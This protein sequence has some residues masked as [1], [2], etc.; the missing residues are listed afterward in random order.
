MRT[1]IPIERRIRALYDRLGPEDCWPWLGKTND[2]GYGLIWGG[3]D[4]P[5]DL[6]AHR[7][8]YEIHVG[9]IPE[10]L[11]IDH[12]CRMRHCVNPAHLE[13]VSRQENLRRSPLTNGGK[14]HCKRGHPFD[15]TNTYI[16]PSTGARGCRECHRLGEAERKALIRR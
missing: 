3:K 14:T 6:R 2:S 7:V 16:K 4:N 13:P 5:R 12:L 9:S 1:S 15:E 11:D 8:M 10:G